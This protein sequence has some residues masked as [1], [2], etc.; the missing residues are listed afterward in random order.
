MEKK[1]V[2]ENREEKK[3][4][5]GREEEGKLRRSMWREI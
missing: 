4:E 1:K 2:N 5:Q 3:R